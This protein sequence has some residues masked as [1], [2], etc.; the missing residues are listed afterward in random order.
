MKPSALR[1]IVRESFVKARTPP[2]GVW[3]GS[4]E[5]SCTGLGQLLEGSAKEIHGARQR[6]LKERRAFARNYSS[7][8]R[9]GPEARPI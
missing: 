3:A 6:F 4:R 8:S 1:S 5:P 2:E 7:R 9:P